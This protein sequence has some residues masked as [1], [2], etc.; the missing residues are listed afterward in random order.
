MGDGQR[1]REGGRETDFDICG[2]PAWSGKGMSSRRMLANVALRFLPLNGVV[3]YS[4]SYMRMPSVHQSTA[5]VC[6]LP[7]ITSGAMYSS[8]PTNELVRKL[9]MHDLVSMVGSEFGLVPFLPMI[10][11]G[12]PPGSDCFER[13]KSDNMMCPD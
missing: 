10:M 2:A 4:I 8:V 5:L 11:V 9:A 3:P 1:R 13:S 6:P 7:L 12:L